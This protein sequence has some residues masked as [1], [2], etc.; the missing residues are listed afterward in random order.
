V[1]LQEIIDEC[2]YLDKRL[3]GIL[4]RWRAKLVGEPTVFCTVFPGVA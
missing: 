2:N 4:M 3:D 1:T